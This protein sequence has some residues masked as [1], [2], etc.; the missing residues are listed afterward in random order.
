M[1][2]VG[3]AMTDPEAKLERKAL[4][5]DDAELIT[6]KDA[7]EIIFGGRVSPATLKDQWRRGR[8]DLSKIGRSYFA[9]V[10]D[11]KGLKTRCLAEPPARASGSIRKEE[12]G[13][14]STVASAA[15]RDSLMTKL[16]SLKKPS[17][18]T[19]RRSTLSKTVP[20]RSSQTF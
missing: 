2:D 8:L 15:A 6:L 14:S 16:N 4:W 7:S 12:P 3:N 11:F 9:S 20:R 1:G 10:A 13:L 5:I 17:G 19:S 18:N